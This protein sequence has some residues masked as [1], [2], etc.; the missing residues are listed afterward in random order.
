MSEEIRQSRRSLIGFAI[1]LILGAGLAVVL[2]Q[3][4]PLLS[5]GDDAPPFELVSLEHQERVSLESLRGKV[6]L[7]DFWATTCPPCIRQIRDLEIVHQSFAPQDVVILGINTEGASA[8]RLTAFAREHQVSYQVLVDLGFAAERYGVS[9][10]PTLYIIDRE[11]KIRWGHVGYT[12]HE[13]LEEIIRPL[14]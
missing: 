13:D 6:V 10:L 1:A 12:S 8:A 3:A 5:E 7:L 14:I 9:Q 2:T 4:N 11:G